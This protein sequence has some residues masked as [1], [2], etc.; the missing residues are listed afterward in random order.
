MTATQTQLT[1]SQKTDADIS[2]LLRAKTTLLWITT[3]EELRVER[4]LV[5]AAGEARYEAVFWDCA[6][7][8]TNAAGKQIQNLQDP[9][10]ALAYIRDSK[11]RQLFVMR[12][13][14]RWWDP[15]VLR[16]LRNLA[17]DLQGAPKNE[18][19]AVVVLTPS[20]EVPNELAGH[21]TVLDY[22]LPER[23]EIAALLDVV[24]AG[25]PPEV[26]AEAVPEG[27]RE[28]AIDA[29]VG[30]TAEEALGCYARSIVTT[31]RIDAAVVSA[32]K[33]RVI[34][35]ERVLTWIDPDPRGLD[36]IGGLDLLKG[37]LVQRKSALSQKARAYGLPAPR[38]VL[39]V[40]VPGTG[41]SLAAKAVATAW[42]LPL[43]RLDLGA[44]KSKF[45]GECHA[46]DTEFLTEHG[47]KR[48][49]EI[50]NDTRLAT[51]NVTTGALEYQLPTARH[52]YE[53]D[54]R[55]CLVR[56]RGL[57][58]TPNHRM[59]VRKPT[60]TGRSDWYFNEA[61]QAF[62]ISNVQIPVAPYSVSESAPDNIT[63]PG[64]DVRHGRGNEDVTLPTNEM[65]ELI[66]YFVADG[67]TN[68]VGGRGTVRITQQEGPLADRMLYL[69]GKFGPA[70]VHGCDD[71]S[72]PPVRQLHV[73]SIP[74]WTYLREH[75]GI[76]HE[77]KRLPGWV[78]RASRPQLQILWDALM[79]TDGARDP[80]GYPSM[81]YSTTSAILAEQ[82]QEVAFRLGMRVTCR[83][84]QPAA[85]R[86]TLYIVS[87]TPKNFFQANKIDW[88]HYQGRVVCFSVPNG[89]LVT[90]RD[91]KWA[92]S[93]NSE[94]NIRKAL[95]V[96]DAVAP[97][98]LWCDEIE[99]S[100]AGSTGPQGDGGVAADALGSLLN[101]MQ[102]RQSDRS[103]FVVATAND[104]RSLPPELLR[105]G[106]LDELFFVDLPSEQERREIVRVAL[107]A[108][109]RDASKIE[110]QVCEALAEATE[111]FTGAEITALVPDALFA[112]FAD[113]ERELTTTDL[114]KAAQATVPLS[115]TAGE[116][117]EDLKKWAVGRARPASTPES[118][119]WA[120]GRWQ[121]LD[122]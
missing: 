48:F 110:G 50:G 109:G 39:L 62:S 118:G 29:A 102:E 70:Q 43:L 91:G 105:K 66:G 57:L 100:L 69:L 13:L 2:A 54:G 94:A 106:R 68:S 40:G 46:D 104:V 80:R 78:L 119:V 112:A 3:R 35:R 15:I 116:K 61:E 115:K 28:A 4:A 85:P 65:L 117:L 6:G 87:V 41:K 64:Q 114:L 83:R 98:I 24:V 56:G 42:G 89:T 12:D 92:I 1:K 44:L 22:P 38:G 20:S 31:K 10:A 76:G 63:V 11:K 14:H 52:E 96:A 113:G 32:E 111:G 107:K 51:F 108:H 81:S 55:M 5:T 71:R 34:A 93:G 21:A 99:K 16:T 8:L 90:R 84:T 23:A 60:S 82:V 58:V 53:Y 59:V 17:K 19:R 77:N 97:C 30:L 26:A 75:C 101:W 18:A 49:D 74:L 36:A 88:I 79:S 122:V 73:Q 121:N 67:S 25:L 7:G 45:V 47:M 120:D 9:N 95:A 33:K 103:V 37:W 27:V 86:K 72:N